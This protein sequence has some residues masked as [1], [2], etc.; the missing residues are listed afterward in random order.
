MRPH[1]YAASFC[2]SRTLYP[3]IQMMM[4]TAVVMRGYEPVR[5]HA[6]LALLSLES[7]LCVIG[8]LEC[9][10][11]YNSSPPRNPSTLELAGSQVVAC[12]TVA[13]AVRAEGRGT[14]N[15]SGRARDPPL[16]FCD[17]TMLVKLVLDQCYARWGAPREW[18]SSPEPAAPREGL[19]ASEP[20][21]ELSGCSE[22]TSG[23]KGDA[24]GG[25][26]AS[27]RTS[28]GSHASQRRSALTAHLRIEF[29]TNRESRLISW[30]VYFCT[31]LIDAAVVVLVSN[32]GEGCACPA[33][34]LASPYQHP[35]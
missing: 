25:G 30:A 1:R 19:A 3:S 17:A 35:L 12:R 21:S 7:H 9:A 6:R 2:L 29:A 23:S 4:L 8:L 32:G 14:F 18:G 10:S 28:A 22:K 11:R 5:S 13:A 27:A 31:L 20:R 24:S 16:L 34:A 15:K 33:P 26:G